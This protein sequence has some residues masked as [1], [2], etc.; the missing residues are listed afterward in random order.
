M[1][2]FTSSVGF[3]DEGAAG[4]SQSL[5]YPQRTEDSMPARKALMR[6]LNEGILKSQRTKV[7]Q[8]ISSSSFACGWNEW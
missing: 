2:V 8:Q 6:L 7:H 4:A 5:P 3:R 1:W